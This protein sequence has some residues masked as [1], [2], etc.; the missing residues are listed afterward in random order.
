MKT[1]DVEAVVHVHLQSFKGFFLSFLGT[2]FL[3]EFYTA[4]VED[5]SC[6]AFVYDN[7][8]NISGFVVGTTAP[9]G[10]YRKLLKTRWWRFAL[11][12]AMPA[13]KQ[14]AIIPR[15]FRA[16]S[17]PENAF[18]APHRGTLLS[19]AVLPHLQGKGIGK[20]L[21]QMFLSEAARRGLQAIDLTT[22]RTQNEPVNHFY[23]KSGFFCERHFSTP[24][25]RLMN[26]YVIYLPQKNHQTISAQK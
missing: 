18:R 7:I 26:E 15:L 11:A 1:T 24:E 5:Q 8:E 19:L 23:Q 13:V 6:I 3:R 14:P 10:F 21:L 25:G 4:T 17:M 2:N 9:S 20:S 16:L 12:A 22:D